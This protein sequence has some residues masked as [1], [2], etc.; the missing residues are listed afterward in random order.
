MR[1]LKAFAVAAVLGALCACGNASSIEA[2]SVAD[3]PTPIPTP[4]T[5]RLYVEYGNT[6]GD[7]APSGVAVYALPLTPQSKPLF[8]NSN[9]IGPLAFDQYGNLFTISQN[10]SSILE[11]R[12]PFTAASLPAT[13]ITQGSG[14]IPPDDVANDIGFDPG[15]DLWVLTDA[16]LRGFVLPLN[17]QSVAE[18]VDS[19]GGTNMTFSPSGSLYAGP[20]SVHFAT[21]VNIQV[22][23]GFPYTAPPKT[24][25]NVAFSIPLGY[26]PDG[27]ALVTSSGGNVRGQIPNQIYPPGLEVLP[28]ISA[29]TT[30]PY[31][32]PF[33][34]SDQTA[35]P[36]T[37]AVDGNGVTYVLNG[38]AQNALDV[39]AY[40]MLQGAMH[41]MR[42]SCVPVSGSCMVPLGVYTGP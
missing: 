16:D 18:V 28:S 6:T 9:Q 33:A 32:I 14:T 37:G 17:A 21:T 34:P 5:G 24:L 38:N 26:F 29:S 20:L 42:I 23:G 27:T 2:S 39:F 4:Y 12:F 31:D 11:Y 41:Q 36:H 8:T 7:F 40:P 22:Y 25:S 13:V 30:V 3:T 15:G 35:L 19:G 10:K 1:I